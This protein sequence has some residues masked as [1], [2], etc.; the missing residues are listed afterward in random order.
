LT[1]CTTS[2]DSPQPKKQPELAAYGAH[3]NRLTFLKNAKYAGPLDEYICTGSDSGH[4]WIYEKATS[5]VVALLQADKSTC[6]GIVPHPN[7][8]LFVTYGIETT[9]K[10]WRATIPVSD[11][12]DDSNLGRSNYFKKKKYEMSAL[13]EEWDNCQSKISRLDGSN[14]NDDVAFFPSEIISRDI[15][16]DDDPFDDFL[17]QGGSLS[18]SHSAAPRIGNNLHN[19][20]ELL[21]ENYFT[22]ANAVSSEEDPPIR[23]GLKELKRRISVI[24]LHHQ[25]YQLGLCLEPACPWILKHSNFIQKQI[26]RKKEGQIPYG[27]AADLIPDCA[28]DL[29]SFDRDFVENPLI[30]GEVFKIKFYEVFFLEQYTRRLTSLGYNALDHCIRDNDNFIE[31][32]QKENVFLCDDRNDQQMS[33]KSNDVASKAMQPRTVNEIDSLESSKAWDALHKIILLLKREGNTALQAGFA[34]LSAHY[35]DKAIQYC[36]LGFMDFPSGSAQFIEYNQEILNKDGWENSRWTPLL[37]TFISVRLNLSIVMLQHMRNGP[38]ACAQAKLAL[39]DLIPF[40]AMKG[41]VLLGKKSQKTREH[42]S[43]E[44][45]TE[46]KELQAKA[47]FRLGSAKLALG[48]YSSAVRCFECSI[49]ATKDADPTAIIENVVLRRLNDAK[50]AKNHQKKR[51]RKKFKSIFLSDKPV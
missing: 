34:N 19:L 3:L 16:S 21:R 36:A 6:N 37:K 20:P 11:E 42:E 18:S 33:C 47:Y 48:S 27:S 24:R 26:K 9:A 17:F 4:A 25:C 38:G 50:R 1:E 51:Q 45:F 13:T 8:P 10:L 15:D 7:L 22:C 49:S 31:S 14:L 12:V 23:C 44:T 29:I 32:S 35:Y 28:S 41:K 5:S 40:T 2:I 39:K 30:C 46:A 43:E